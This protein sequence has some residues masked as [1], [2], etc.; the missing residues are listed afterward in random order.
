[1]GKSFIDFNK[2]NTERLFKNR[3]LILI[4]TLSLLAILL[5]IRLYY[6]QVISYV[7][8][9]TLSA[10]NHIKYIQTTPRRGII[11]DRNGKVLADNSSLYSIEINLE[12][13][14]SIRNVVKAVDL[15]IG[16]TNLEIKN[17]YKK[18]KKYSHHNSII[19]K[20][21]LT[22]IEVAK[23]L[24][25]RYKFDGLDVK[26]SLLRQYPYKEITHHI[27]GYVG[28]IDKKDLFSL[29]KKKYENAKYIGKNGVEKY[30]ENQLYGTPGYKHVEI[31]ARGRQL[32]DIDE[33]FPV[34]G[35]DLYLTIDIELQEFMFSKLSKYVGSSIAIN[36]K[37]GEVLGMISAPAIDPNNRLWKYDI[38]EDQIKK[39]KS[40]MFNRAINGLYSP[41]STIK[42]I[43]ALD[44]LYHKTINPLD[45]VYAGPFFQLPTSSRRFRD[46]KPKGHGLVDLEKAIVQSCDVYFYM[47]ANN[48]GIEKIGK[49]LKYFSFGEKTGID[50]PFESSGVVP[51]NEW[52]LEHIGHK[53]T[54]GDT[55]IT[56]IGQG[57]FLSTPLQLA[58]ATSIIANKGKL[59]VPKLNKNLEI[60]KEKKIKEKENFLTN[61]IN[62]EDWDIIREAM[63]KVVNQNNGTAYWATKNKKNNIA[64]KTGTVQVYSLSQDTDTREEEDVPKHLKDHSLYIGFAPKDNPEIVIATVIEN[65]GSGSAFAAPISNQIINYYL[66]KVR[67]KID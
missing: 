42:P 57:Y 6:L 21:N 23:I 17:F 4:T 56:G 18:I 39:L 1:M 65:V 67:G 63:F 11:Y 14:R 28:Y 19:L 44:G 51:S 45:E 26:G 54:D 40:P 64:G 58:Y 16:L 10:A 37:N 8:Y 38:D 30:Y 49:F 31:N 46:W 34:A 24:S 43:V 47:L 29:D 3:L 27:L 59:I 35:E 53:W 52:K 15:E 33:K 12:E 41:G 62:I 22:E 5:I 61:E 66:E 13:V 20:T 50:M 36:P 7:Q 48:L 25:I 32:R 9:D 2:V 55:V 60:K